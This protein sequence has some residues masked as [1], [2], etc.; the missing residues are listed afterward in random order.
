M[1]ERLPADAINAK[2]QE[3]F[4]PAAKFELPA[5]P[6]AAQEWMR[7][8]APELRQTLLDKVFRGWPTQ[9]PPLGLSPVEEVESDGLRMRAFD[10]TS[11]EGVALRVSVLTAAVVE[12]PTEIVINVVD[13]DEW[14][15]LAHHT[16]GSTFQTLLQSDAASQR[17]ESSEGLCQTL[18]RQRNAHVTLAPRGI[19]PTRLGGGRSPEDAN[20]R[21]R[22]CSSDKPWTGNG[23]RT[24]AGRA[25]LQADRVQGRSGLKGEYDM[26]GIALCRSLQPRRDGADS[27]GMRI[28]S[29]GT[30]VAQR[31]SLPGCAPGLGVGIPRP[32]A[33]RVDVYPDQ[34]W[35]WTQQLQ[36]L[37]GKNCL[38]Y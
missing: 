24:C 10:F 11:E 1:F 31:A 34:P 4:V 27:D 8:K 2:I 20:I 13:E 32:I 37:L 16:L 38:K 28:A 21:R 30:H 19:G 29:A 14:R 25:S 35:E 9:P 12:R 33:L 7:T 5:T 36:R 3:T 15:R 22:S 6:E 17:K 26:A 18:T 23:S